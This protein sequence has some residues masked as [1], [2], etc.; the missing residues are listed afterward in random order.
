MKYGS[1][2]ALARPCNLVA[3]SFLAVS[4]ELVCPTLPLYIVA[5][6]TAVLVC[7]EAC[8]A[9]KV[10]V[11]AVHCDIYWICAAVIGMIFEAKNELKL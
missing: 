9:V 4:L 7:S 8:I 11:N 1:C 5:S 3:V 2:L 10:Y 6:S